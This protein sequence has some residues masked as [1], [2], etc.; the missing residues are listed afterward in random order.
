MRQWQVPAIRFT[1]QQVQ[2]GEWLSPQQN[3]PQSHLL[4]AAIDRTIAQA[5]NQ[6]IDCPTP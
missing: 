6:P 5:L 2:P 4:I 3:W 1:W